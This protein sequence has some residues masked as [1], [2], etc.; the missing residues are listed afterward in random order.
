MQK[1]PAYNIAFFEI[2]NNKETN[3]KVWFNSLSGYII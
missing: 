1:K 2:L 3:E